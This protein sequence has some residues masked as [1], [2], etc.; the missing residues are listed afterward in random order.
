MFE[1]VLA[2]SPRPSSA[3]LMTKIIVL[4]INI[5]IKQ[6]V[7]NSNILLVFQTI[8]LTIIIVNII[9]VNRNSK[10]IILEISILLIFLELL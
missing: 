1:P 3:G 6:K 4:T 8:F 5:I 10:I 9:I 2:P 7:I